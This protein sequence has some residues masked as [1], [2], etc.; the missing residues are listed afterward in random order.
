MSSGLAK[1]NEEL[2]DEQY[3]RDEATIASIAETISTIKPENKE[4]KDLMFLL[5]YKDVIL[6]NRRLIELLG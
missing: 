1:H 5:S 4:F 3:R 2:A 6:R